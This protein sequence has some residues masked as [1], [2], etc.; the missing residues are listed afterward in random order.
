MTA[1][2]LASGGLDSSV[3]LALARRNGTEVLALGFDYDQRNRIELERL[4]AIAARLGCKTLIVPLAMGLWLDSGLV[5]RGRVEASE[6]I[7]NYVPARNLIFLAIAAS[8]AEARGAT[9]IYLGATA[10]DGHHPDCTPAFLDRVRTTLAAGL[11]KPPELRTPLIG[12]S[13]SQVVRT[14]IELRV[15]LELTWSCHLAGPLPCG[16]CAPC[17]LRAQTFAD[18]GLDDPGSVSCPGVDS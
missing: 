7:T 1:L 14:A 10:A 12:L 3:C 15:P 5:G 11:D 16:G 4:Q 18:L 9:L 2:V 13:K 6:T 17:R 8:I